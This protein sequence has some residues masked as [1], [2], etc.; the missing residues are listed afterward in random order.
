MEMQHFKQRSKDSGDET[1]EETMKTEDSDTQ[2]ELDTI[3]KELEELLGEQEELQKQGSN[4]KLSTVTQGQQELCPTSGEAV[5]PS[6]EIFTVLPLTPEQ[7]NVTETTTERKTGPVIPVD[8][9]G[10]E[11]DV[12]QCPSCKEVVFTETQRKVGEA[13]CVAS[14]LCAII[15]GVAGCCLVPFFLERLRNVHHKCPLCHAH[16]HTHS[17]F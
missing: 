8:E 4:S 2:C 6:G 15:G 11:A 5:I 17:P 13:A 14:C 10:Q 12:T 7:N 9:L 1:T 3:Q 16:I